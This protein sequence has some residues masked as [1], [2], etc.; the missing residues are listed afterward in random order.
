MNEVQRADF[1]IF[2]Q[3]KARQG[4]EPAAQAVTGDESNPF[5]ARKRKIRLKAWLFVLLVVKVCR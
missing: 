2:A 1:G 4:E 5:P 3:R